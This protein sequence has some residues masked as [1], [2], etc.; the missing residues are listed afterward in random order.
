M[1][2]YILIFEREHNQW[3]TTGN[4]GSGFCRKWISIDSNIRLGP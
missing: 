1:P 4:V 3:E 2:K